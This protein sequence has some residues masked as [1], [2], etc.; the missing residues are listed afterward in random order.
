MGPEACP[1][2]FDADAALV[3]NRD[4][5]LGETAGGGGDGRHQTS[6]EPTHSPT[7]GW[8]PYA[9]RTGLK[10]SARRMLASLDTV[11]AA[12]F[13]AVLQGRLVDNPRCRRA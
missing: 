6:S 13:Q 11:R 5:T 10:F 8:M 4:P 12:H 7:L 3:I 9:A 1:S 2:L